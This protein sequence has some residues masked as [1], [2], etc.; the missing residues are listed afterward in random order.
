[1]TNNTSITFVLQLPW[2]YRA[3]IRFAWVQALVT[4][5]EPDY[6]AMARRIVGAARFKQVLGGTQA[7]V[8]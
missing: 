8:R 3:Y 4:Q 6:L 5:R 2:W 1:M 7:N